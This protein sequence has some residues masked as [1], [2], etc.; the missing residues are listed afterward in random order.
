MTGPEAW[1][2]CSTAVVVETLQ[3]KNAK[4][5]KLEKAEEKAEE[6]AHQIFMEPLIPRGEERRIEFGVART[7]IPKSRLFRLKNVFS[8]AKAILFSA[9]VKTPAMA[10]IADM[11]MCSRGPEIE[12]VHSLDAFLSALPNSPLSETCSGVM[13]PSVPIR[14]AIVPSH[15]LPCSTLEHCSTEWSWDG[16]AMWA[17]R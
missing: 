1:K 3:E 2:R 7:R 8:P 5:T 15:F 4:E 17:A 10:N 6:K 16:F 11:D 14:E 12:P 13:F 9:N